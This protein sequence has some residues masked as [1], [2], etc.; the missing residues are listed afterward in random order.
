[1]DFP[2]SDAPAIAA[3]LESRDPLVTIAS[4]NQIS[5]TLA[6]SFSAGDDDDE[7]R[8]YEKAY[9]FPLVAC[10]SSVAMLIASGTVDPTPVELLCEAAA[11]RLEAFTQTA[12]PSP[13]GHGSQNFVS[14]DLT[15]DDLTPEDQSL[16]LQA[17]RMARVRVAEMRLYEEDAVRRGQAAGNLYQTLQNRIDAA[18]R[19]F[20]QTFLPKS[21]SMVDYLHLEILRSLGGGDPK[22][23]G[24]GYP[25]PLV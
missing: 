15:W 23:L 12:A 2:L 18:R 25:G 16:H 6:A 21:Q 19:E 1:M 8:G 17:Q 22:L 14:H 3:A 7:D 24:T 9:L 5:P 10:Q 20:L 11:M 13:A 4:R